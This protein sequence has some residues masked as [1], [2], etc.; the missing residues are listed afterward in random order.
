MNN[1]F[2]MGLLTISVISLNGCQES[3]DVKS[4]AYGSSHTTAS[5]SSNSSN[6]PTTGI[7][8]PNSIIITPSGVKVIK[9]VNVTDTS[10]STQSN[11]GTSNT[12]ITTG[13]SSS[14][15]N[16]TPDITTDSSNTSMTNDTSSNDT[17]TGD[18]TDS[19]TDSET[20]NTLTNTS[21]CEAPANPIDPFVRVQLHYGLLNDT[22]YIAG[23]LGG[24]DSL[25]VTKDAAQNA[26]RLKLDSTVSLIPGQLI[27]YEGINGNIRV[28]K[29]GEVL[30]DQ[31]TIISGQGLETEIAAGSKI[32]NFY[33]DPT[34]PNINGY[35]AMADFGI[36]STLSIIS[37]QTHVLLGDSWF[38]A[39]EPSGA[40]EFAQRLSLR[41]PG[42]AILNEG[43]GGNTLC[44]LIDRFDIDVTPKNP[45]YV[46]I[47][48]NIND[49][50]NDVSSVDYKARMQFL[51]AKIQE[52]GADAIVFDSAPA[53]GTSFAGNDLTDLSNRYASTLLDLFNTSQE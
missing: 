7:A 23:E 21:N 33:N 31:V 16:T 43:I 35:K 40:S 28:A 15:T 34:H 52:I 50:F 20:N 47:N 45:Q 19:N 14:N 39:S 9:V 2:S 12:N 37:N 22:P 46:W 38:D 11:T 1:L 3:V 27:T 51:I 36:R 17:S 49:Y 8:A 25:I 41:L 53:A 4:H 13:T 42:S 30:D 26:T 5:A 32:S 48:S 29:I 10:Q 24:N 6:Q 18:E 44:D